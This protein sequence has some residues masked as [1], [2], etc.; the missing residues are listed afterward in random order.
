VLKTFRRKFIGDRAFFKSVLWLVLPIVVQNGV[1]NFVNLLDN[2][3]VGALGTE[4]ISGVSIVNQLIFVVNIALFGLLAGASIFGA[5][6][7]GQ[8]DYQGV[9]QSFRFKLLFALLL[10]ALGIVVLGLRGEALISLFLTDSGQGG[11]LALT[12]EQG[13]AY[14]RI[15]VWG[16]LPYA[17]VQAY[18]STLREAG[19]TLSP[20]VASVL[21]I[22]VNLVFNYLL[23]FGKLGFPELG[24]QGAALA[25][26]LSHYVEAAFLL[27]STHLRMDKFPFLRGAYRSLYIPAAL[28][29]RIVRTGAP[30]FLNELLWS[31]GTVIISQSYSTRGLEVVAASNIASTAWNLFCII[32]FGMSSAI[33]IMVGQLLGAGKIAEAKDVDNKLIFF[34]VSLHVVVGVLIVL[35]APYIP[36]LYNTTE[37]VRHMATQMLRICGVALPIAALYNSLYFTI[38]CGG[39]TVITL[40]FD[41]CFTWA[42]SL[43]MVFL[44]CRFSLLGVLV[45]YALERGIDLVR[46]VIGFG[47]LKSGLWAKNLVGKPEQV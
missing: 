14:L 45:I 24:A 46:V 18:T 15:M 22:L 39:Q 38:R 26:V 13:C 33:S 44:L 16:M 28:L 7:Y 4:V 34:N 42:I 35:A 41:S 21:A 2:V 32:L 17:V 36:L 40:L 19:E 27:L 29:R 5:Q 31:M 25:T 9:V 10:T 1:S 12:L 23:I 30:L 47:I 43:P 8:G 3:M 20:M 37:V 11:D 6:Y